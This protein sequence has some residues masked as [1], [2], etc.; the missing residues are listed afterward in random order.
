M[1]CLTHQTPSSSGQGHCPF[2]A[3]AQGSNPSGATQCHSRK[4]CHVD[5]IR[6]V[7]ARSCNNSACAEVAIAG[8]DII[9]IRNSEHTE[10]VTRFTGEEWR[11]FITGVKNDEFDLP[12]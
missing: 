10:S 12:G 6:W 1:S 5:D 11:A 8:P 2:K 4:G 3:V 7:K 9:L